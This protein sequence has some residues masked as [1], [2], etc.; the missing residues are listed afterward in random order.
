MAH[1]GWNDGLMAADGAKGTYQLLGSSM[2]AAIVCFCEERQPLTE[3][4]LRMQD[5]W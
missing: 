5:Y 4:G 3:K 2:P 1:L